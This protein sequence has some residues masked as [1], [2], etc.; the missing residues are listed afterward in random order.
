MLSA[1]IAATL[2]VIP[3]LYLL[4]RNSR[5]I[6]GIRKKLETHDVGCQKL[7]GDNDMLGLSNQYLSQQVIKLEAENDELKSRGF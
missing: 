5:A 1:G 4:T 3:I 7:I 2:A 6:K